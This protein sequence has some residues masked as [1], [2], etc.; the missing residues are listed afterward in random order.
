MEE[1]TTLW[2][3]CAGTSSID[4][5]SMSFLRKHLVAQVLDVFFEEKHSEV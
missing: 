2:T 1:C 5:L 4:D 3:L